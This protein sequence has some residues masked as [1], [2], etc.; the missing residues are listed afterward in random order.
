METADEINACPALRAHRGAQPNRQ[1]FVGTD[2][3]RHRRVVC[4]TEASIGVATA[5]R[6]FEFFRQNP[7]RFKACAARERF[8]PREIRQAEFLARTPIDDDLRNDECVIFDA[9]RCE[10]AKTKRELS[11]EGVTR[12]KDAA[13][14]RTVADVS[15]IF[16]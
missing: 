4:Q 13:V 14:R 3:A 8:R 12:R 11:A 5:E 15:V 9:R 10:H 6:D 16:S 1:T 7:N 2:A